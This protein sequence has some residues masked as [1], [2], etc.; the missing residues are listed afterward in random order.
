VCGETVELESR[1]LIINTPQ[2]LSW[3][4]KA[5]LERE[6]FWLKDCRMRVRGYEGIPGH[7]ELHKLGGSMKAQ[8]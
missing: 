5:I 8:Q 1:Q 4:P 6:Q 7:D 2:H 3:H